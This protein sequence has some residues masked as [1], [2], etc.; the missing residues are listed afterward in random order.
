MAPSMVAD[1]A[2]RPEVLP[3]DR[4][5]ANGMARPVLRADLRRI[6][7]GRN[8]FTVTSVWLG[9]AV[10]IASAVWVDQWWSYLV[11]FILMGPMYARFAILM[12]ESA[13]KLLFTDKR[14]NDWAGAWL[15]A[16][17]TWTP[18]GLYRRGHFAYHK[19]EF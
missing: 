7:D 11:A 17:P 5:Q 12:H 3:T 2:A 6:A 15:I 19:E 10:I 14:V 8:A 13:H 9:V 1:V 16:Y 18:I 4:L